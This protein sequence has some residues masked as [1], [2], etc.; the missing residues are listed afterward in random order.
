MR[1]KVGKLFTKDG[2]DVW[3]LISFCDQPS[4]QFENV[5]TKRRECGVVGSPLVE[6]FHE[7]KAETLKEKV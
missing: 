7:L 3:R 2:K 1:N 4:L 6:Q 5:E